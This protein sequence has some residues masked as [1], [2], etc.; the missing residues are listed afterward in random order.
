[1]EGCSQII[2]EIAR[3]FPEVVL[4]YL[5]GSRVQGGLG[6]QSDYDIAFAVDRGAFKARLRADLGSALARKLHSEKIDVVLLNEASIDLAFGIISQ[7]E[8]LYEREDCARVDF[9]ARVLNMYFDYLPFL[10]MAR[11]DILGGND[12]AA[13]AQRYREAL[14]RTQRALGQIGAA[15]RKVPS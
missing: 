5:F 8:L 1:M 9:E 14:G 3:A 11:K 4:A 2:R 15:P 7:G 13:R 10:R 12:H 6:P